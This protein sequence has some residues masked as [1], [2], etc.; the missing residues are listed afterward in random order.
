[1][2][3]VIVEKGNNNHRTHI[4]ESKSFVWTLGLESLRDPCYLAAIDDRER[5]LVRL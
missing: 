5:N 1:M 4:K 2:R 3:L